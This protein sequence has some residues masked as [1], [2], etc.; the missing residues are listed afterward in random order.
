MERPDGTKVT[1]TSARTMPW[2]AATS[3]SLGSLGPL[4]PPPC[5]PGGAR[6]AG[7][8]GVVVDLDP[9]AEGGEA[10]ANAVGSTLL[11]LPA[12]G[13]RCIVVA[14]AMAEPGRVKLGNMEASPSE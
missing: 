8:V 12:V 13:E 5:G 4:W 6:T 9:I 7:T 1:S 3:E 14:R 2:R 10:N 11:E